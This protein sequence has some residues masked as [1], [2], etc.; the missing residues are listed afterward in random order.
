VGRTSLT[1]AGVFSV[2]VGLART[3]S[4][5]ERTAAAARIATLSASTCHATG[6]TIHLAD[7]DGFGAYGG[8]RAHRGVSLG[9]G[10]SQ[11]CLLKPHSSQHKCHNNIVSKLRHGQGAPT[12]LLAGRL[13]APAPHTRAPLHG[14]RTCG[15]VGTS[16]RE[17]VHAPPTLDAASSAAVC[18]FAASSAPRSAA[19]R[20]AATPASALKRH[21]PCVRPHKQPIYPPLLMR[22]CYHMTVP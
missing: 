17:S 4:R 21:H 22:A 12:A 5:A 15:S 13:L 16:V 14:L 20:A 8:W 7:F 2:W 18:R 3:L 19:S 9:R 10:C 11:Q 1:S 6:G